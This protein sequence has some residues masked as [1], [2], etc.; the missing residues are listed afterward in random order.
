MLH[1]ARACAPHNFN[2][3]NRN[4][5]CNLQYQILGSRLRQWDNNKFQD[6]MMNMMNMMMKGHLY[7]AKPTAPALM[8]Q[9]TYTG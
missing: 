5:K 8:E 4:I 1:K 7:K 9:D 3:Q 2:F 6:M